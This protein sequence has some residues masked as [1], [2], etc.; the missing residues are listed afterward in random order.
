[1]YIS[2]L[3]LVNT[4]TLTCSVSHSTYLIDGTFSVTILITEAGGQVKIQLSQLSFS[5]R[6]NKRTEPYKVVH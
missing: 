2:L 3:P 6:L 1:M 4:M 5:D